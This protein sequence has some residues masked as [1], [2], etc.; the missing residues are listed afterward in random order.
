[1]YVLLCYNASQA[2]GE[3][4]QLQLRLG[5]KTAPLTDSGAPVDSLVNVLRCVKS[6]THSYG[7]SVV[8]LGDCALVE[9]PYPD[10]RPFRCPNLQFCT[11]HLTDSQPDCFVSDESEEAEGRTL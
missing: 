6:A 7:E 11:C 8:P 2:A 4:A 10:G 1:M 9:V 3:G 5:G